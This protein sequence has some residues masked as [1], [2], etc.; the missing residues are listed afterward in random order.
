[1]PQQKTAPIH[2]IGETTT[3]LMFIATR[4]AALAAL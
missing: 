1:M 2:H 3:S 4:Y